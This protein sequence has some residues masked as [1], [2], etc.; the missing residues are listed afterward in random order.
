[1]KSPRLS[2]RLRKIS[3]TGSGRRRAALLP[4]PEG[5][6]SDVSRNLTTTFTR[7]ATG[8]PS[9]VA[10]S[11]F[12]W[13]TA[14][15]ALA[16]RSGRKLFATFGSRTLPSA[17]TTS[18][19][20][21]SPSTRSSRACFGYWGG[22]LYN[23][24]GA[25]TLPPTRKTSSRRSGG[26][27]GGLLIKCL[28]LAD[29]DTLAAPVKVH[30][31]G[32]MRVRL[33]GGFFELPLARRLLCRTG[34]HRVP[35]W[36]TSSATN[37]PSSAI[38]AFSTTGPSIPALRASFGYAGSTRR[39][40]RNLRVA[41]VAEEETV[42]SCATVEEGVSCAS[43]SEPANSRIAASTHRHQAPPKVV[44]YC[45]SRNCNNAAGSRYTPCQR[46]AMCRCGPVARPVPPLS[47]I[48]CPRATWSP[49][50]TL[51]SERCR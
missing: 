15:R 29:G 30:C 3:R 13:L 48:S 21:T 37:V 49:A 25:L 7:T 19:T 32:C 1:M 6:C 47:P 40:T 23:M 10:G 31:D 4:D 46:T 51:N 42:S 14:S 18:S 45:G 39:S 41:V 35:A 24:R 43:S 12:H 28:P 50:F 36:P 17:V 26:F 27:D 2:E 33:W 20:V 5:Y 9:F 11:N 16:S 22:G 44:T 38:M 8:T 34:Q